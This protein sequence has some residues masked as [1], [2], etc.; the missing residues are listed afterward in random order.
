MFVFKI[1]PATA[2]L[3]TGGA[4]RCEN[5]GNFAVRGAFVGAVFLAPGQQETHNNYRH[6]ATDHRHDRPPAAPPLARD[7]KEAPGSRQDFAD[8]Q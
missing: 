4:L 3:F 6:Y 7:P 1:A 5:A 2:V 8:R